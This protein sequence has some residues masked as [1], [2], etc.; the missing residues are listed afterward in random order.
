MILGFLVGAVIGIPVGVI[1]TVY[2]LYKQ[3][4]LSAD[5]INWPQ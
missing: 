2:A 4:I 5:N 3:G 1:L